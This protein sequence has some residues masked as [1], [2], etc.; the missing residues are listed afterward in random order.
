MYWAEVNQHNFFGCFILDT[1]VP[2]MEYRDNHL[3][4]ADYV[5]FAISLVGT[6]AIGVYH[7]FRKNSPTLGMLSFSFSNRLNLVIQMY[8]VPTNL[9]AYFKY[10]PKPIS[11]PGK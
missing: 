9:S 5:I 2:N 11:F 7:A 4:V 8:F 6:I 10:W 3:S 1:A